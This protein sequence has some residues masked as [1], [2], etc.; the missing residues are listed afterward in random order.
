MAADAELNVA[1][2]AQV[3]SP[4]VAAAPQMRVGAALIEPVE[5]SRRNPLLLRFRLLVLRCLLVL[6]RELMPLC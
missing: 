1:V 4:V 5:Q 3:A 2:V 6:R